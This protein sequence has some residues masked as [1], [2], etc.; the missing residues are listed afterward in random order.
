M[1]GDADETVPFAEG[2]LLLAA[3]DGRAELVRVAGG[4]HTFNVAHGMSAPSP[5]LQSAAE[6]TL[7][8][9][10]ERLSARR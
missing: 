9:F 7:R 5:Q 6:P 10:Q 1:H 4:T 8:F 3:S 2:E